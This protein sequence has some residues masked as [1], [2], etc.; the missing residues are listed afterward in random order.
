MQFDEQGHPDDFV[1]LAVNDAFKTLTGLKDVIGKRAT[2]VFPQNK[3]LNP[4]LFETYGGVAL[5][6]IPERFEVD[7]KPLGF[8]LSISV[9]CPAKGYFVAVFDN[10]TARKQAELV[11]Q[12][13]HGELEDRVAQRTRELEQAH[14]EV[15][16][17]SE[18]L[19]AMVLQLSQAEDQERRRVAEVFHDSVQ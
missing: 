19:R 11:L 8:Y 7:F 17:H 2:Q 10:I 1:Y 14:C 3:E 13:A 4:E 15:R 16:Q 12:R 9:Y 5:T 18:Q 6:G